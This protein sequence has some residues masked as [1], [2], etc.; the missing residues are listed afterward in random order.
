MG[1]LCP[2]FSTSDP[3]SMG[4]EALEDQREGPYPVRLHKKRRSANLKIGHHDNYDIVSG[5][6]PGSACCNTV[7][8]QTRAYFEV[9][10]LKEGVFC[11]GVANKKFKEFDAF[12][13]NATDKTIKNREV[14][15][16][17]RN[18]WG[19]MCSEAKKDDVIGCSYDLNDVK[20]VLRFY[21]N[22]KR[23]RSA[24]VVGV[25]GDVTAAISVSGD[26][27]L[28]INWGGEPQQHRPAKFEPVVASMSVI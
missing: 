19:Y 25:T 14:K 12:L 6:F 28:K 13:T 1:A 27:E 24:E 15:D 17:S 3:E 21:K 23:I 9:T 4:M 26:C 5:S 20:S 2:C 16:K 10:V 7:L 11:I 22:G 8:E 18:S